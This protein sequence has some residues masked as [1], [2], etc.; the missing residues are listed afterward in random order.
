M[1]DATEIGIA[2]FDATEPV[3][4]KPRLRVLEAPVREFLAGEDDAVARVRDLGGSLDAVRALV[5]PP[6][7]DVRAS[8]LVQRPLDVVPILAAVS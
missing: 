4:S 3:A 5:A 6:R 8:V 2:I 7:G 1:V